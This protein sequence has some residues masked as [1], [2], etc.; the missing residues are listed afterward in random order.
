[1]NWPRHK[2]FR[3]KHEAQ[4]LRRHV[5]ICLNCKRWHKE[6]KP[7]TCQCGNE[8]FEYFMSTREAERASHLLM[9]QSY[10][11]ISDL[12]FHAPFEYTENGIKIFTWRCDARYKNQPSGEWIVEDVKRSANPKTWDPVF[13]L[14]KKL[15][16]ARFGF[17]ISIHAAK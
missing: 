13:I 9:L 15:I 3:S 10:G 2:Q 8:S 16:E 4:N 12:E 6:T 5:W 7:R 17:E 1:M 14:K 11:R